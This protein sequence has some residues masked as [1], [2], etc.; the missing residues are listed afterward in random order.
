MQSSLN[1]VTGTFG[2]LSKYPVTYH[3]KGFL[4]SVSEAETV[5]Y[6]HMGSSGRQNLYKC[7]SGTKEIMV[8]QGIAQRLQQH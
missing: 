6:L 4:P 2:C 1:W 7:I 5:V 8:I 3:S